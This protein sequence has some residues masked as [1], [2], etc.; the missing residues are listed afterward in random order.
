MFAQA[1]KPGRKSYENP[2][3][4]LLRHS[5]RKKGFHHYGSTKDLVARLQAW[6][7][8]Q[9]LERRKAW[10]EEMKIYQK[11]TRRVAGRDYS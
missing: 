3:K 2:T 8:P 11:M 4:K 6:W 7:D 9:Y 1:R 5:A 10:E